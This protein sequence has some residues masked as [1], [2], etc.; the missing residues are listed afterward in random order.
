MGVEECGI[1]DM[2]PNYGITMTED[3][4]RMRLGMLMMLLSERETMFGKTINSWLVIYLQLYCA[5]MIYLI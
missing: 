1:C 5:Q 3:K 4:R 2:S